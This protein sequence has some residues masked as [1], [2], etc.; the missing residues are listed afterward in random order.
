MF[1]TSNWVKQLLIL[2]NKKGRTS[3]N[4][5]NI[6]FKDI[7][8]HPNRLSSSTFKDL[9]IYSNAWFTEIMPHDVLFEWYLLVYLQ[10]FTDMKR[11]VCNVTIYHPKA[12][13]FQKCHFILQISLTYLTFDC[14]HI[15]TNGLFLNDLN[16]NYVWKKCSSNITSNLRICV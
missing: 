11:V 8:N 14:W 4:T 1:Y 15:L 16:G 13:W 7:W 6:Y 3:I 2:N 5:T 10:N 9:N 12:N